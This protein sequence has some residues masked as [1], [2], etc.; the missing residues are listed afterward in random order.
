MGVSE[1]GDGGG[2]GVDCSVGTIIWVR[3]RNGSWWP[4]RI[5]GPEELSVS[6]L[7]SPR[8]GTPVKLLGREDASVDWYNLEKSKRVKAFRCGEF[9]ACIEKAEASLGVPIKKREKYARREDAILHALELERKQLE[10]KQQKQVI[11]SNGITGKPLGTLKREFINLSASDTLTGNDESLINS[12]N[13]IRKTQML[14]RKAG[15]LH[16]EEN[17]NNSMK[18]DDDHKNSKQIGREEDISDTFHRMRGLQDFGLRIASK[19]KLPKSVPW[20]TTKEPAENN[21]DAFP[22]AGHIVGGRGHV[23]SVKDALEINRKRSHGGVI[24]E[25][26]AK[27]RDRRRPL[28]QVL[29]SSAKLQSSDSSQFIHYPD[30]VRTQ[31]R[32]DH[33]GII[34][35]AKRSRCIYVPADSV[36]SQDGGY[37]S[38][39]MQIPADQI[40]MDSLDRPGSLEEDCT[41][42][43]M[44]KMTDSDSSLKDYLETGME[45]EDFLG[46]DRDA[47]ASHSS[48]K[49]EDVDNDEVPFPGNI[50]QLHPYGHSADASAE[51]GV[52]KW[53]MKGKRNTRNL[54]KRPSNVRDGKNCVIGSDKYDASLKEAA[55][56][57]KYSTLKLEKMEP[58]SQRTVEPDSYHIK[59]EDNY[60]SDDVD[61]SDGDFLQEQVIGYSNQRYPLVSKAA[62]DSGRRRI[63]M[64][65]LGSDS[66]LMMTPGWEADGPSYVTRRKYWEESGECYDPVYSS[67]ISREIGSN[68]FNVD[69]KVKASYQ[70]EH[71]PLVSLMSRLNGKAIIGHPLQI[72]ILEDGSTG[73]YFS[74]NPDESTAHQPVWRTARRTAMQR[75]PRSNPVS[76]LEDDEA[77]VSLY[78]EIE[79]KHLPDM[80]SGH[81]KNQSRST[82]KKVFHDLRPPLGNSQKKSL[83][84][85]SLSNQKTRTLSSFAT[86]QRNSREN[87]DVRLGRD[88]DI[89]SGLMKPEGQL[90]SV[91]CV[92]VKVAFSRILEA[93]RRPST[94]V[95]HHI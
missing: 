77:G 95:T 8:S 57:A 93:V 59:E 62:R 87:G 67:H 85:A 29:Q 58:F 70:G 40:G 11:T 44:M 68:L 54:V 27:K 16:E 45:E 48:E 2:S 60:A 39:D 33:M 26:L 5:L 63:G 21:M 66:H 92:P 19:K 13:A 94:A 74:S 7:M 36:D 75:V 37:S 76:S 6:H 64:N 31:G 79:N 51:A 47:S 86:E 50:S 10:M 42:S 43:G 32:K 15:L 71:V 56:G 17:I 90:P 89:L 81:S 25:S 35:R 3:R 52:S 55:Y 9:D 14:P 4:G 91:T 22:S 30:I 73:Q 78:S 69:L 61:L 49:F 53:H 88:R 34:C 80:Y 84:R 23:S 41:S 20:L 1:A 38:E 65:N 24:E 18:M 28:H 46:E 83:K 82:K 12:K 72:E